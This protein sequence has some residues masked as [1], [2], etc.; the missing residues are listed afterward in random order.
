MANNQ[1]YSLPHNILKISGVVNDSIVDGPGIRYTIFTQGCPHNCKGCHN[2]QTHSYSDG[3]NVDI[4]SL[5]DEIKN[6]PLLDGVTFSGGEPF[7]QV[8]PLTL[9]AQKVHSIGLNVIAYTGYLYEFLCQSQPYIQLL[10]E[11]DYLVDGPF[12]LSERDSS[13]KFQGSKN[14]R[15][16]DCKKSSLSKITIAQL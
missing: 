1:F 15:I 12:I 11:C 4:N 6:N 2:P 8:F 5:F 9:L 14:Q 13:L 10:N 16:I 3:T 7:G